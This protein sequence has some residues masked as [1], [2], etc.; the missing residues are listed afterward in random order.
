MPVG[1]YCLVAS[2]GLTGI[3]WRIVAPLQHHLG[4]RLESVLLVQCP[5]Q[6]GRMECDDPD[7]AG[8]G[9]LNREVEEPS[10]QAAATCLR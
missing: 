9:L 3:S 2:Q 5:S 7:M 4:R 6:L 1:T 8:M 10:R